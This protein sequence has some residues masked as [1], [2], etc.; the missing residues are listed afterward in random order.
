VSTN[1]DGKPRS[2]NLSSV[3]G[4]ST[5]NPLAGRAHIVNRDDLQ[6]EAMAAPGSLDPKT[7]GPPKAVEARRWLAKRGIELE[8]PSGW[9][10]LGVGNDGRSLTFSSDGTAEGHVIEMHLWPMPEDAH[11]ESFVASQLEQLDEAIA[12]KR[13]HS[14]RRHRF[15][16]IAG[17][18]VVGWGPET[19]ELLSSASAED[20]FL[21]TDGTGRRSLSFR[22]IVERD[23]H[24]Q[25]LIIAMSS[26]IEVFLDARLAY[27][28]V[29]ER[30]GA[31]A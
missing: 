24:K 15:G 23:G 12:L 11:E 9:R 13:V 26:P 20:L 19:R 29:L 18:V 16:Q 27:D 25:L 21:A 17:I 6:D 30:S 10:Y 31:L 1:T 4:A 5:H 8:M 28:A 14:H 7:L 3:P 22:G 2:T